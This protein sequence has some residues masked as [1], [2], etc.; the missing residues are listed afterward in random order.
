MFKVYFVLSTL[1]VTNLCASDSDGEF[2]RKEQ[3]RK[4]E[5]DRKYQFKLQ[6]YQERQALRKQQIQ[7][8]AQQL[9][10]FFQQQKEKSEHAHQQHIEEETKYQQEQKIKFQQIDDNLEQELQRIRLG[11]EQEHKQKEEKHNRKVK[12]RIDLNLLYQSFMSPHLLEIVAQHIVEDVNGTD[13]SYGDKRTRLN[14]QIVHHAFKEYNFSIGVQAFSEAEQEYDQA[15]YRWKN[16]LLN[17]QLTSGQVA[18]WT[19]QQAG[20]RRPKFT[21]FIK[22][23]FDPNK[24]V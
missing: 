15:V 23:P 22:L 21:D 19:A 3:Q 20:A 2:E 14:S 8:N 1:L 17:Y 6:R 4:I 13:F 9:E 5:Q 24:L 16:V 12:E 10:K 11:V 7:E 18:R